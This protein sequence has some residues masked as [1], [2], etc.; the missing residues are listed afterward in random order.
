MPFYTYILFSQNFDRFY[1]GQT[2]NLSARLEYHNSGKVASTAPY[3]PWA[4]FAYKQVDSRADAIK[5]EKKLKNL[6]SRKRV[7]AFIIKN[8]FI[9]VLA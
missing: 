6:K 2:E 9:K 7:A 5:F 8:D 4:L 3:I 1:Y